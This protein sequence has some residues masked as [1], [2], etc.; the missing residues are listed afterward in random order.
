[1]LRI[2]QLTVLIFSVLCI[3]I[4]AQW[5]EHYSYNGCEFVA[6]AANK[7]ISGIDIGLFAYDLNDHTL[8][9]IGKTNLLT[10]VDITAISDDGV[11]NLFVGYTSGDIDIIN[12]NSYEKLNIPELRLSENVT[13][14]GIN[15]F[16]CYGSTLYCATNDGIYEVNIT[17]KE[18]KSHYK[19]RS[20]SVIVNAITVLDDKIYVATASGIMVASRNSN[21]LE[22][23]SEWQLI[24]EEKNYSDIVAIDGKIVATKGDVGE[25]NELYIINTDEFEDFANVTNFRG[26]STYKDKLVVAS[27]SAIVVYDNNLELTKTLSSYTYSD[28]AKAIP[29]IR[30]VKCIGDDEYIVADNTKGLVIIDK[31]GKAQDHLPNGPSNN[32]CYAFLATKDAIYCTAGG[33]NA[34][35]ARLY[36]DITLHVYVNGQW[37]SDT[38]KGSKTDAIN[39]CN[40]KNHPDSIYMSSWGGG[41]FKIENYKI[42]KNYNASNSP[43]IGSTAYVGGIGY[44]SNSNLMVFNSFGS[45]GMWIRTPENKWYSLT[46]ETLVNLHSTLKMLVTSND[47]CWLIITRMTTNVTPGLFVFNTR[48]TLDDSDDIFRY[49]G[50]SSD[51]RY[52]GSMEMIDE[53]GE[54]IASSIRDLAEDKNGQ[55]WIGCDE[56]VVTFDNNDILFDSPGRPIFSRIKVPRNDGTNNADYLLDGV[57]VTAIAVDGA[58]RKWIGTRMDGVYLVSEDGKETIHTFN[59]DNSPL[60]SND[61]LAI[62]TTPNNDE[63]FIA[64]ASGIISYRSDAVEPAEEMDK[65]IVYPNPVK[66]NYNGQVKITGFSDQAQVKIADIKGRVVYSTTSNGGMAIWDCKGLDGRRVDSGVYL[67]FAISADGTEKARGQI[68]VLK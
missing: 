47:N 10:T 12:L 68:V 43:I 36:R 28:G 59:K 60:P 56:G 18:I 51:S 58:N 26:L 39:I 22:A 5:T 49:A 38:W 61:I 21:L 65:L 42:G 24:S 30:D 55:I 6:Y 9:K 52:Y 14:K 23:P 2:K 7:A 53:D 29:N 45:P 34:S 32:Y 33:I 57:I 13:E 19:L 25:E 11:D 44:D 63:V 1:M 40:D 46:Y 15:K 16:F 35:Y 20:N 54:L 50:S 3:N 27:D 31:N 4:S 67:V 41:I 37:Q 64:T 17:K 48:G 66:S 8:E 62:T